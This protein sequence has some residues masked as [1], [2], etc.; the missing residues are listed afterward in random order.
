MLFLA[1]TQILNENSMEKPTLEDG[2]RRQLGTDI[3]R[4]C[5]A[6][7]KD[8]SNYQQPDIQAVIFRDSGRR[9]EPRCAAGLA[10]EFFPLRL[11]LIT[12]KVFSNVSSS[13]IP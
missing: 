8:P 9:T 10:E 13:V 6:F 3:S 7:S 12:L 5:C 11:D 4:D 1:F 2:R